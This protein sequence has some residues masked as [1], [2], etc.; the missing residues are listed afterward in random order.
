MGMKRDS[1]KRM[2]KMK[3]VVLDSYY[4]KKINPPSKKVEAL[5]DL[6]RAVRLA[7]HICEGYEEERGQIAQAIE[8]INECICKGEARD[9]DAAQQLAA[10][11]VARFERTRAFHNI[12]ARK[13]FE[14]ALLQFSQASSS[15]NEFVFYSHLNPALSIMYAA[16]R[17]L[18]QRLASING[19]NA[20][21]IEREMHLRWLRDEFICSVLLSLKKAIASN[22]FSLIGAYRYDFRICCA[23]THLIQLSENP[24]DNEFFDQLEHIGRDVRRKRNKKVLLGLLRDAYRA[25]QGHRIRELKDVLNDALIYT[26]VNKPFYIAEQL[27]KTQD[28]YMQVLQQELVRLHN[29]LLN[30]RFSLTASSI[31][32]SL[33][34]LPQAQTI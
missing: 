30:G 27:E 12:I 25:G 19:K 21:N 29:F 9:L 17:R 15:Q 2:A 24:L 4:L 6:P 23:L 16:M 31:I 3:D 33:N 28:A 11:L 18:E 13:K 8:V 34:Q 32:F 22:P 20:Y 14:N 1:I 5:I 26:S 10:D 7:K